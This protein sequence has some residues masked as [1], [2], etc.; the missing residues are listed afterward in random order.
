MDNDQRLDVFL[1][2]NLEDH[3]VIERPTNLRN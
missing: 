1:H 2:I 3:N